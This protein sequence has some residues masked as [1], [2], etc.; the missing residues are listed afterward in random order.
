MTFLTASCFEVD[1]LKLEDLR[2][3]STDLSWVACELSTDFV[4]PVNE[5]MFSLVFDCPT[6]G[7]D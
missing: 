7:W 5:R 4:E 1:Q 6:D 2:A 3:W